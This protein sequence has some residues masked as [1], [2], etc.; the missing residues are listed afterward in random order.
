MIQDKHSL[1]ADYL[2]EHVSCLR[3]LPIK[4]ILSIVVD[5]QNLSKNKGTLFVFGNGGSCS[6]AEHFCCDLNKGVYVDSANKVRAV[7]LVSNASLLTAWSNDFTYEDAYAN[8]IR[9]NASS[10][11][12]LF[13]ISASGKSPN[14]V[15]AALTGQEM[16]LKIISITGFDGGELSKLSDININV[17][18]NDMQVVENLHLV[19]CHL[20]FKNIVDNKF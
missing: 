17:R 2:S 14:I 1:S 3:D 4:D 15:R 11:D 18:S 5:I 8:L 20:I 6:T 7:S 12:A 13:L 9:S 19:I 16:G 10:G